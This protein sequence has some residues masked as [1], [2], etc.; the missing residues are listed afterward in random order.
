MLEVTDALADKATAALDEQPGSRGRLLAAFRA[1]Q[2]A[3]L[4]RLAADTGARLGELTA[5]QVADLDGGRLTI[6][7][8]A[9]GR[10]GDRTDQDA[11]AAND[12]ARTDCRSAMGASHRNLE[13]RRRRPSRRLVVHLDT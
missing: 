12:H 4:V 8:A 5:L 2:T 10:G 3:L 1:D 11:P 9:K 6:E 7:R 13:A